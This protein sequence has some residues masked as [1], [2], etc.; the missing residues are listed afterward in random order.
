MDADIEGGLFALFLDDGVDLSLGL[1]YH[2]FDSCRVDPAVYDELLQ[3]DS[4]D[5]SSDRIE[6]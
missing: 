4:G 6:S 5:L 1:L 3:S 2:L